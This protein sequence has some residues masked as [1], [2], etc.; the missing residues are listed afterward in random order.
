V[1][2]RQLCGAAFALALLFATPARAAVI[3][4]ETILPPGQSGFV[5]PDGQSPHGQDQL[6]LFEKLIFKPEPLGGGPGG[7]S[8]AE[9]RPGVTIRRDDFGVP[10]I[11]ATNESDLWW[12]A[13]YAVAQDR[14][15]EMELFRRR[16]AGTLAEV[17][18]KDSLD[19]DFIA[20]R[21]YYTDSE[22]MAMFQKLP[23]TLRARLQAYVDGVNAWIA[24]VRQTPADMP[25]E[26][27]ALNVPLTDWTLLDSLRIGVL[28][29]RTIPSGDGAELQ[30]L[31]A[32][33]KLGAKRFDKYLPLRVPGEI[34]TI[35]ARAGSFPSRPGRTTAQEKAAYA[36][37]QA[38]LKKIPLP[39][40]LFASSSART[41]RIPTGFE[42]EAHAID[43]GLGKVGGSFMWAIRRPSDNHTFF[44]NGPQLGYQSPNTFVE[45]DLQAPGIKLHTAT[46]P[47]VPVNSNGYNEHVAWGVTSGLSD[48]DDLYVEKLAGKERY[49]YKGKVVK[50]SCR[51]EKFNYREN[52]AM[53][54]VD[55]RICRTVHGP[56]RA[57]AGRYAFARRYAIW[58]RELETL[59]GLAGIGA[60]TSLK[61]IGKALLKTTWTENILAAD[62][63]GHI[64]YWHPGLYP[65]RNVQWDERLP[66]PG[67]GSAEWNGLL[68]RSKDP[69]V[70]DPPSQN[71]L[72]NWNNTPAKD[73]TYGDGPAR[74]QLRG[75]FHRVAMMQT[76]VAAAAKDPSSFDA[77]TVGI[78]RNTS[79]IATQRPVAQKV[80]QRAAT[81]ATGPAADVLNTLLAWDGN[82]T[83]TAGDGTLEPGVATWQAFK[84]A[85]ERVM[86]G[87]LSPPLVALF[88]D[89]GSEGFVEST[90]GETLA[91]QKLSPAKLQKAAADAAAELTKTYNSPYPQAWR[92]KRPTVN[93]EVQGLA[94]AP[95]TPLQNRGTYEMAVELGG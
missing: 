90:Y 14:L 79:S 19:D 13:G 69:H 65:L 51:T 31:A 62:D 48:D 56:V 47:G 71:W 64:G 76:F 30:N 60:A 23:A 61:D 54:S 66:L 77:G 45:F 7:M 29:A 68:P 24:H 70:I 38:W 94:S 49:R 37:S 55:R 42:R 82:F 44:F 15:G 4:A 58:G 52:G 63:Q 6:S 86:F 81:G 20:R 72:V 26:F 41:A 57:T 59:E 85:A 75:S 92:L 50:M 67:D 2:S 88:G 35:P 33:R 17:L 83:R 18:G 3:Q 25:N 8:P 9:P 11:T 22:L 78:L 46:A 36:R 16:G 91:L 87:K 40:S 43:V 5:G 1:N 73:W 80:L 74:E 34:R 10:A 93:A 95:P 53:K 89:P 12:G 21:D 32:L 28:L 27:T 84:A 39:K